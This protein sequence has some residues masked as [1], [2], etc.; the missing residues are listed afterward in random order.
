MT[1][2][3][4]RSET[5]WY[6]ETPTGT[7]R[8]RTAATTTGELLRDRALI[9]SACGADD[10]GPLL[11]PV[12][13]PCRVVA[14][15]ANYRSHALDSGFQPDKVPPAFFRKASGSICGPTDDI[16]RPDHVRFLD[17]EVEL[18]IVLGAEL[19]VG[20]VVTDDNLH[21]YVAGLVVTNDVSARD[22]QLPHTQFYEAKSYPTFTPVG[23]RLVLVDR[24]EL[25]RWR[26]LRLTLAVNGQVRQDMLAADMLVGLAEGLTLLARFQTMQP[27]DV[28]LTGTPGGTALKSP[29]KL[30]AVLAGLLPPYKKWQLFFKKQAS[31]PLYLQPG[32]VVTARIATDDGAIDLG[33]QVNTVREQVPALVRA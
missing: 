7:A 33:T 6:V 11:S 3:I 25:A 5:G 22:V 8:I 14:Q 19:A 21:E 4:I 26:E 30:V 9:A 28:V 27:G 1:V 15:M 32:D 23:P 29:P 10:P 24:D 13:T 18:G 31:N 16:V 12:T 17:Y 20:A 2:S